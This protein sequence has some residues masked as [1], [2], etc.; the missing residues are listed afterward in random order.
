MTKA[1]KVWGT[2]RLV[3]ANPAFEVHHISARANSQCSK[4]KHAHKVNGF[5]VIT[6]QLAIDVWKNDYDLTD[7][8]VLKAGEY[9][10]V[11]AGEYHRFRALTDVEAMEIY[12]VRL[13]PDDIERKDVGSGPSVV[14][15]MF[16]AQDRVTGA[17]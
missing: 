13:D 17:S 11:R 15:E 1:G 6:G 8:T 9:G 10:E 5:Y 16:D 12:F 7:T 4:H 14:D 3:K 2:T